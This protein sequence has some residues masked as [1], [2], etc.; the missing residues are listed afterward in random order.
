MGRADGWAVVCV[1]TGLRAPSPVAGLVRGAH[2]VPC[3][4]AQFHTQFPT[5]GYS[6][7]APV[8]L[9][10]LKKPKFAHIFVKNIYIYSLYVVGRTVGLAVG[11]ALPPPPHPWTG[12]SRI[13]KGSS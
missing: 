13:G 10:N 9:I 3:E 11:W 7:N 6:L 12:L 4:P 8:A 2:P 1:K 5:L